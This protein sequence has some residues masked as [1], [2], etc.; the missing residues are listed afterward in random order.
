LKDFI[1]LNKNTPVLNFEMD[2]D[3]AQIYKITKVVNPE[4]APIS[5]LDNKGFPDRIRLI[6][7]WKSRAIPI[8]RFGLRDA[9]MLM[10]I[11]STEKLVLESHGL[12]LSDQYWIKEAGSELQWNEINFFDNDFSDDVGEALFGRKNSE[13]LD[14][15]SPCNT[16]DG[17]LRKKWKIVNGK[18]ALVKAGSSSFYQEPL[19]E[20]IATKI[21]KASSFENFIEYHVIS[22][23][24]GKPM[25]VC[26]NF[27]TCDTELITARAIFQSTKQRNEDSDKVHYVR[28]CEK[29]GIPSEVTEEFLSDMLTF[30][31][32][33]CNQ[34][35]HYNNFG[36]IRDVNTL[37]VLG[38]APFFDNG[39]SLWYNVTTNFI[40]N[41]GPQKSYPFRKDHEEQIKLV[42][43]SPKFAISGIDSIVESVMALS[44]YMEQNRIDKITSS[45]AKRFHDFY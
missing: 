36:M 19:N 7:W 14:L 38:H 3:T 40:K 44:P 43:K 31:Y 39:S 15:L 9:L 8:S 23:S 10:N 11:S 27:V 29:L 42:T 24:E 4:H 45:L 21:L 20:L 28:C 5:V 34:D 2:V 12:S 16:S 37:Q 22:D 26:N 1:L 32:L 25:S 30:D 6:D 18:R 41:D 35:R 17:W 13:T 33:I